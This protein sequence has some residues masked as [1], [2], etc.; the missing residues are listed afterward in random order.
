[1][2]LVITF[3]GNDLEG[4]V[5]KRGSRTVKGEIQRCISR[6]MAKRADEAIVVSD[7]LGKLLKRDY[8]IIP[9]GLDLESFKPAPKGEARQQLGLPLSKPLIL[10]AASTLDNP[11]KRYG[12]ATEA[13][14]MLKGSYEAELVVANNVPHSE[15]PK[16]MNAC[17]ALLLTSVHEGS[18]NVVKEALACNLPVVSVDVGD[19]AE[20]IGAVDGCFVCRDQSAHSIASALSKVLDERRRVNGTDAICQLSEEVTARK[21]IE[22]YKKAIRKGKSNRVAEAA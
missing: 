22:V 9:S 7:S 14:D 1:L 13:V 12:L 19:V 21:V 15:M 4:I 11:R 10:F 17:D 6:V 16:Y 18:P 8:H 5:G 20:R 2:P 3:R